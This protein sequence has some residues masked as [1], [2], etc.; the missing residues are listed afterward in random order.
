MLQRIH[1]SKISDMVSNKWQQTEYNHHKNKHGCR[2]SQKES[3]KTT[4]L[5]WK[6]RRNAC[7]RERQIYRGLSVAEG[8]SLMVWLGKLGQEEQHCMKHCVMSVSK[9]IVVYTCDCIF[10]TIE[11]KPDWKQTHSERITCCTQHAHCGLRS[12]FPLKSYQNQN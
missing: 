7:V 4:A 9:C 10:K 2:S 5:P 6:R 8:I 1:P 12:L 3:R 11:I